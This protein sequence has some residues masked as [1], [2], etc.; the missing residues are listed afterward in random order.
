MITL[1]GR[2][3]QGHTVLRQVDKACELL[4]NIA[5]CCLQIRLNGAFNIFMGIHAIFLKN[6]YIAQFSGCILRNTSCSK[7]YTI[8][9]YRH[10]S[11]TPV[12]SAGGRHR[13]HERRAAPAPGMNVLTFDHILNRLRKNSATRSASLRSLA[14]KERRAKWVEQRQ[15]NRT[16]REHH[17]LGSSKPRD[18]ISADAS[19][20]RAAQNKVTSQLEYPPEHSGMQ[21]TGRAQYN[22]KEPGV[23]RD[24]ARRPSASACT[25]T[26]RRPCRHLRRKLPCQRLRNSSRVNRAL[27]RG[28]ETTN[29]RLA[30]PCKGTV[31][32]ARDCGRLFG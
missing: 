21:E 4:R 31:V 14:G 16:V 8:L 22:L 13:R 5:R 32:L 6:E 29:S 20:A 15:P 12:H 24:N 30:A 3:I 28:Y 17:P 23:T 18:R 10:G 11:H 26:R 2:S 27:T 9:Q 7:K 1:F 25:Y 19:R